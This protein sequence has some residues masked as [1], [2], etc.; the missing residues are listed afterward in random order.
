[1][2]R[3]APCASRGAVVNI[4]YTRRSFERG[5]KQFLWA[6]VEA[7]VARLIDLLGSFCYPPGDSPPSG[8]RTVR[9][10]SRHVAANRSFGQ[11][12]RIM[13]LLQ[14]ALAM[15]VVTTAA[16]NTK[17][18]AAQPPAA[19]PAGMMGGTPMAAQGTQL[20][21]TMGAQLDSLGAMTPAQ[22]I[23]AMP[24]HQALASQMM[25]MMSAGMQGMNMRPDSGWVALSDS[26]AAGSD[27]DAGHDRRR[28]SEPD[29]VAHRTDAADDD[30][31][32]GHDASMTPR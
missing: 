18:D 28:S 15:A 3:H 24:G 27:G 17:P 2:T 16:C 23:A 10:E 19:G 30:D 8:S 25:S 31:V 21:A 22:M 11:E 32:S 4:A 1:M 9:P 14:I 6:I 29:A 13:R 5:P 12:H 7:R 26:V 20:M